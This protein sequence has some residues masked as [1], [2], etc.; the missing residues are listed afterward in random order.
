MK[1]LGGFVL[2]SSYREQ[3]VCSVALFSIGSLTPIHYR[4]VNERKP[5]QSGQL[6][7]QYIKGSI[8]LMTVLRNEQDSIQT[9]GFRSVEIISVYVLYI[10]ILFNNL[11]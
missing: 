2:L 8:R 7:Y 11:V 1:Y 6:H 4:G 3:N 10:Y 5:Y 9:A